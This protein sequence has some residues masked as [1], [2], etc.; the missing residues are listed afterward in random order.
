LAQASQ[1]CPK[2][3]AELVAPVNVDW[4]S[5]CKSSMMA[6]SKRTSLLVCFLALH[7]AS[8]AEGYTSEADHHALD[9]KDKAADA[10]KPKKEAAKQTEK[11]DKHVR[12]S[13]EKNYEA[14]QGGSEK[15]NHKLHHTPKYPL[16]AM[17][18]EHLAKVFGKI[19][20]DFWMDWK[21]WVGLGSWL[22]VWAKWLILGYD[23][24]FWQ[25][26]VFAFG[27]NIL[28]LHHLQYASSIKVGIYG[29]C[30]VLAC[31]ALFQSWVWSKSED[32]GKDFVE[33]DADT[34]YLD[35]ALPVEQISVLFVAQVS[36]WW[37]FMTSILGNFDFNHVNYVFWLVAFL[38]MQMTMIFNRGDD[39]VLGAVFPIHDVFKMVK[40][41]DI[42]SFKLKDEDDAQP[43]TLSKANVSMRG[44]TGYF[45]NAI[46]REIMAYTIPLMLMGFSEPMDFV[47]YC[48]GVNFICTLDDMTKRRY[49]V[50]TLGAEDLEGKTTTPPLSKRISGASSE[51]SL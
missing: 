16:I 7:W 10:A 33:F 4:F 28:I 45:C 35:L 2:W 29:V 12:R 15:K 32:S 34:L 19:F 27:I 38:S 39:S 23:D 41:A 6:L 49:A 17:L 9:P 20:E 11:V 47:V 22:A 25:R 13:H 8:V 44:I 42:S 36:I 26:G 24:P 48:V 31:Q 51:L 43:F 5:K 1:A 21:L 3:Q 37:F 18:H 14:S 40:G 30:A 46:L 50:D